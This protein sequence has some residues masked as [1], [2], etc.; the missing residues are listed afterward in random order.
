MTEELKKQIENV[1]EQFLFEQ[2]NQETRLA[3]VNELNNV[4]SKEYE[5]SDVT[6]VPDMEN[7]NMAF[8]IGWNQS[9]D[10]IV[11]IQINPDMGINIF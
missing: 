1:I 4:I 6:V 10:I 8:F 7:K 11:H 9:T 3:I 2:N 5:F